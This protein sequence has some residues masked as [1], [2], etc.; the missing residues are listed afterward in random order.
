M[1]LRP[2]LQPLLPPLSL[3]L[4]ALP[5]LSN[6][7]SF[8]GFLFLSAPPLDEDETIGNAVKFTFPPRVKNR[9]LMHGY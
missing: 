1:S 9:K 8:Y 6:R 3:S 4:L 5:P 2:T 7:P